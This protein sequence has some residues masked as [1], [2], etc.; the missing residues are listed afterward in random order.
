MIDDFIC[1]RCPKTLPGIDSVLNNKY[2]KDTKAKS[3]RL[4]E[5]EANGGSSDQKVP[6]SLPLLSPSDKSR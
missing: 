5:E 3:A 6:F 2:P 4:K 1:A